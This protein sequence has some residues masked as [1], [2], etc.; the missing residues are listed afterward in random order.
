MILSEDIQHALALYDQDCKVG[1]G[2]LRD[3]ETYRR[4][5]G[6]QAALAVAKVEDMMN[7]NIA[8]TIREISESAPIAA[9]ADLDDS[10]DILQ[11]AGST[12]VLQFMKL[13]GQSLSRRVLRKRRRSKKLRAPV[14]IMGGRP[15]RPCGGRGTGTGRY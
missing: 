2:E 15:G 6:N 8:F 10:V 4:L 5:R 14:L 3:P 12:F 7:T 13:M 9:N 11:L 1:V